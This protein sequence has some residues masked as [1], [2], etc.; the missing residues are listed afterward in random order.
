MLLLPV[1]F[2]KLGPTFYLNISKHCDTR[3][4]WVRHTVLTVWGSC[5]SSLNFLPL[6]LHWASLVA[7]LVKNPPAMRETWVWPWVGKIPWRRE[8]LP[9]PVFWPGEFHGP[10]SPWDCKELDTTEW[11]SLHNLI[12]FNSAG[13]ESACNAG[14]LGSIPGLGR[15]PGGGHGNPFHC[16][17]LENPMDR[18]ALWATVHRVAKSRTWLSD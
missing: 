8:R 14:D 11:L 10:Y 13:K 12:V 4:L 15:S 1:A 5:S 2:F 7:Q 16:S 6:E 3:S 9:T 18:G 17:C